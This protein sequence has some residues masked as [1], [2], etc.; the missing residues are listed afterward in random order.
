MAPDERRE[1]AVCQ[2]L[3]TGPTETGWCDADAATDKPAGAQGSSKSLQPSQAGRKLLAGE[4]LE[5]AGL[6]IGAGR[7][8]GCREGSRG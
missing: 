1:V 6:C 4:W 5:G 8:L 2:A 7:E 3:V